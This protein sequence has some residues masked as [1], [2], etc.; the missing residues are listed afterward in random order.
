MKRYTVEIK[1]KYVACYLD[2]CKNDPKTSITGFCTKESLSRRN[3]TR[4][5]KAKEELFDS[6]FKRSSFR[7]KKKR[8][9]QYVQKWSS[10]C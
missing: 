5:L 4:W 7:T 8:I 9:C 6:N 10:N 1:A 3:F 2:R